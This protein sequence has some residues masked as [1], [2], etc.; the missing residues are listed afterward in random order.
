MT[1]A[2]RRT[3][4]WSKVDARPRPHGQATGRRGYQYGG[5]VRIRRFLM[6]TG[7]QLRQT[8]GL[9]MPL[10]WRLKNSPEQMQVN[11]LRPPSRVRSSLAVAIAACASLASCGRGAPESA[12]PEV[13]PVRSITIARSEGGS[14]VALSGRIAAEDEV[15]LAFRIPGRLIERTVNVGD[16]VRAGQVLARLEQMNERNQL[17]SAQAALNAANADLIRARDEY[18]RQRSLIDEGFTTRAQLD[19]ATAAFRAAEA[20]VKS[21]TAQVSMAQDLVGFTVLTADAPGAVIA[22]GAEPGEVVQAGRMIVRIALDGG[23]DAVFEV[24][25]QVVRGGSRGSKI[26]VALTDDPAVRATGF[27]REVSPQADP[28]TGTFT[29][30]VGLENPPPGMLLGSVVSGRMTTPG[31]QMVVIPASALMT[32]GGSPATWVVDPAT[33]TVAL[34]NVTIVKYEPDSVV[35]GEGLNPGDTVVIAGVQTLRPGQKVRLLNEAS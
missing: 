25:P 27:V 2:A 10:G 30:R 33:S 18:T 6:H 35:V 32:S 4:C 9:P 7:A 34:R 31:E 17:L 21:A 23:V 14:T 11:M 3:V 13:R 22:R 19:Q 1:S 12:A 16:R 8:P 20:Q 5:Y 28:V 15:A 26:T 29:V 24:P